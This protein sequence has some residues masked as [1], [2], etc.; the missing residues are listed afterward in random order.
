VTLAVKTPASLNQ[1][2]CQGM[3]GIGRQPVSS[4]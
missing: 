2:W 4:Q 3:K 1:G